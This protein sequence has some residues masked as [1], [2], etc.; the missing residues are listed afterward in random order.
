MSD[1]VIN[2]I[3]GRAEGPPKDAIQSVIFG[4]GHR[5]RSGKDTVAQMI[6]EGRSR[7][8]MT[9]AELVESMKQECKTYVGY[10]EDIPGYSMRIYSFAGELKRE[11]NENAMKSGGMIKL[12][13]PGLYMEEGGFLQ[14]NG[15]TLKLPEWVQY[16][17]DPPMDDPACPYG[18]QRTLLQ[19]WGTEYRRSCN[20]SYW[21]TRVAKRIAKDKP[22]V[23]LITDVR[24]PNEVR[25][26]QKYGEAVKVDRPS[27]PPLQ[28]MAGAHASEMALAT[29]DGWDDVIKN[30]A[31]LETLRE[32]ALFSFD[33]LM[34]AVPSTR[35][36]SGI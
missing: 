20:P 6:Y 10:G 29:F 4:F 21:E 9:D 23:A 31:D 11:V 28:G 18:K 19:W 2:R 14:E 35:P 26:V 24:F 30:D 25:F 13:D 16:D 8:F 22:E 1:S 12:F 32:R 27:L 17:P 36:T 15:N 7:P 34:S 33:M 5:A 3:L